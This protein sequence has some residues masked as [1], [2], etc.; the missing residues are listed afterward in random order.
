MDE[1]AL[2]NA[3]IGR[4]WPSALAGD[5]AARGPA[6]AAGGRRS[7]IGVLRVAASRP[8]AALRRALAP[9]P[10]AALPLL[11]LLLALWPHW[12]WLARRLNDG[13]DEPWGWLAL[14]TVFVLLWT[15]RRELRLPSAAALVAAGVLALGAAVLTFIVPPIFAAG[16]AMMALAVFIASALP[17]RP[18][19]PIAALLLLA[20]PV[21][22]SLQF[23]LGYPLRLATAHAAA[24]L[25]A[26]AG[27]DARAS[28]AA[29]L[30]NGRTILVDPPCAGIG[31][32]WVGS[33]AAALASYLN[34]AKAGRSLANG[35]VAAVAVFTANVLRNA[36]L[37][38][39]EAGLVPQAEWLHG[40]IGLAA[41]AAALLP[42]IAFA[43][44]RVAPGWS[45]TRPTAAAQWPPPTRV[46]LP[47]SVSAR[48]SRGR[49]V[50]VGA[51]LAAAVLP[52]L[53]DRLV[54]PGTAGRDPAAAVGVRSPA[55]E[56][57]T[58][59]RGQPLTRLPPTALE[60]RFAARF[61][62]AVARF[63]DG[64]QLVIVRHVRRPTRLLHPAGDCFRGAGYTVGAM[65]A[66]VDADGVR[67][68]CFT[69]AQGGERLRVCER[70]AERLDGGHGWT[71]VSAWFWDAQRRGGAAAWWAVTVVTPLPADAP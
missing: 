1:A 71:D 9:L 46:R 26:V 4:V 59:F 33:W 3:R 32:L 50:F 24:P 10:R 54:V 30:W 16:A 39:P 36:L 42:A 52:P 8:M 17:R 63:T 43:R 35:C 23:Y 13:S 57:P 69:A 60:A 65:T 25:L 7:S 47:A 31:M 14:A 2:L 56:W 18:A 64:G 62:G 20:L 15:A 41:F 51:C 11:L 12:A 67:W 48:R 21:I 55:I 53:G 28:S 70:I 34:D 27:I 49:I 5:G 45:G 6:P 37:F 68:R 61:P 22:A 29:L 19:A 40:A 58:H 38:F 66:A 44:L